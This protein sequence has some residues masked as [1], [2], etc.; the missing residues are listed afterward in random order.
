MT[1]SAL[2]VQGVTDAPLGVTT[3][4]AEHRTEDHPVPEEDLK[5][6]RTQCMK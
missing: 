4:D 3:N 2:R 6:K 5:R 1:P